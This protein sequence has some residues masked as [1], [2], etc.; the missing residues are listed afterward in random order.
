MTPNRRF[1][2][3]AALLLLVAGA[4]LSW[5]LDRA[6]TDQALRLAE[7]QNV[8]LARTLSSTLRRDVRQLLSDAQQLDA[9]GL[10]S[11]PRAIAFRT[12]LRV[13][14]IHL[15]IA[16]VKIYD[17]KG[18]TVF[19]SELAQIGTDSSSNAGYRT[20]IAGGIATELTFRY[21]FSAFDDVVV[22]RNLLS[23]YVPIEDF[24]G[25]IDSVFEIYQD[26][27]ELLNALNRARLVRTAAIFGALALVYL[28][29]LL[30]LRRRA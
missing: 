16:K 1:S 23:S 26:I 27:T 13:H 6:A 30:L 15:P 4:G 28:A 25:R 21:Q 22:D 20:A 9:Q 2:L 17:A 11:D 8:G 7:Q 29:L 3:L 19:S 14:L 10:R 12:A 24:A 5:F 18:V